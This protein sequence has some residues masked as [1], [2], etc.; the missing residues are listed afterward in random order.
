MMYS[1]RASGGIRDD[2]NLDYLIPEMN[3]KK[4]IFNT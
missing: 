1:K 3:Y 2:K 4:L